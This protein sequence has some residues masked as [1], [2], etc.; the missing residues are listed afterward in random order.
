MCRPPSPSP[1][2]ALARVACAAAIAVAANAHAA[3]FFVD[4]AAAADGD[5]S[6]QSPWQTLEKVVAAGAFGR[7]IKAG[8]TVWLRSGYH[9]AFAIKD[10]DYSPP[11]SIVAV[12][13]QAP[14][15]SR[16]SFTA[17]KGWVFAGASV[18]PSYGTSSAVD[19]LVTIDPASARVTVKDCE[20]FSVRDASAW[21]ATEW[22]NSAASGVSVR[23]AEVIISN[24]DLKNVRFGISVDG[25]NALIDHNRIVNF[26]ADG[27]RGLGDH[28]VFQYNLVKNVYVS[29]DDGDDNHDDGFQS[30]SVGA[31]G[32]GTGVVK[33]VVLRGNV[34]I[35][36]E[37]PNQKLTNSMQ[38]IG[39]FD[40]MFDGWVVE[41][42]VVITDHWH[43]IS[44]YGMTNSRIVN[45]TVID[46]DAAEPGP[47]W[48]MVTAHKDGTPSDNVLVRNNLATDYDLSGT[49]ITDDHN[50]TLTGATLAQFFVGPATP[51]DLHLLPT[52]PAIDT[53]A[54]EQ[55]PLLDADGI[56]RP[57]G[58]GIDLGAYEWHEAAV[59][60]VDGGPTA[61]A[62]G[63]ASATGGAAGAVG[64]GGARAT[65]GTAGQA[66]Y[67]GTV[68]AAGGN[69]GGAT[70]KPGAQ[71][72]AKAGCA[73]GL[74]GPRTASGSLANGA[75]GVLLFFAA[76]VVRSRL[77]YRRGRPVSQAY[78]RPGGSVSSM[79]RPRRR[80]RK[81]WRRRP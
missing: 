3:E 1:S 80:H 51:F 29:G 54:V 45:N 6:S 79:G 2:L 11:I 77:P 27:L 47:P 19:T 78:R 81:D 65:G 15:L 43:G 39:C 66:G 4:P 55:A 17:T 71:T 10:G 32:V 63:G 67:G 57:Q 8:D 49:A 25:A 61:G 5:G 36:R 64:A 38:G 50:T 70:A 33:G 76:G 62:T 69:A 35:N 20:L 59:A 73:C 44:F 13:G 74:A 42:N 22:I 31:G 68:G 21:G 23:G 7:T 53:G 9:G 18:S 40:G 56:T 28:D 37:D 34:F 52:A 16:V 30:W 24:N 26:S 60:P 12:A 75:L 58:G 46:L 72:G 41:N 48:I 14:T